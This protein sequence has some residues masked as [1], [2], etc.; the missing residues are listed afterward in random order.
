MGGCSSTETQREFQSSLDQSDNAFKP[1][2]ADV[3]DEIRHEI[4]INGKVTVYF[5][6]AAARGFWV[7][8]RVF[9]DIPHT[10]DARGAG[11]VA[12]VGNHKTDGKPRVGVILDNPKGTSSGTWTGDNLGNPNRALTENGFTYFS[13]DP[14]HGCLVPPH[15]VLLEGEVVQTEGGGAQSQPI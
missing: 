1:E 9:V 8:D 6:P 15:L 10:Q 4:M 7:G 5:P 12:W 13:C 2:D 11:K 3:S 14:D